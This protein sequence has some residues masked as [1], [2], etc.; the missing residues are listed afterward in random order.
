MCTEAI[1]STYQSNLTLSKAVLLFEETK[2]YYSAL[3]S[4]HLNNQASTPTKRV[5][6]SG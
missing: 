2:G 6:T 3:N 5:N 1:H 4:R